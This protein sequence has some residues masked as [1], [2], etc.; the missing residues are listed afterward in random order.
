MGLQATVGLILCLIGMINQDYYYFL[1]GVLLISTCA[2]WVY[3]K[4]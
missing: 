2:A 3:E 4:D 1:F